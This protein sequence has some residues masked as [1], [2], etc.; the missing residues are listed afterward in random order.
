M[1]K[2]LS[3]SLTGLIILLTF[4]I[5]LTGC[6]S[7]STSS[8][9]SNSTKTNSNSG[10]GKAVSSGNEAVAIVK[11]F[12]G[13]DASKHTFELDN[14]NQVIPDGQGNY[15]PSRSDNS[16][17]NGIDCYVVRVYDET[18]DGNGGS[19]QENIGWYFVS[20]ST[21]KV[22]EMTDPTADKLEVLN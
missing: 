5:V 14:D 20:K 12:S 11:K 2:Y 4:L 21:G 22:F 3:A 6:G 16:V 1:K 17:S 7:G 13:S 10:T 8:V 18:N 19:N 15:S 9:N